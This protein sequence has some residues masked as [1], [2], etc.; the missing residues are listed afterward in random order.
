MPTD[1]DFDDIQTA[2]QGESPQEGAVLTGWALVAE[3][4][5]PD[6]KRALSRMR[7]AYVTEWLADGMYHH[8][9]NTD[10]GEAP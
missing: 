7:P 5:T 6:G 1:Y 3:W 10:W 4:M 9:L 8:A 2:I